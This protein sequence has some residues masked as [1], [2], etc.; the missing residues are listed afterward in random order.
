M[1]GLPSVGVI[2][3]VLI[4]A[5]CDHQAHGA[6]KAPTSTASPDRS[7]TTPAPPSCT[8]RGAWI[9][10]PRHDPHGEATPEKAVA[11]WVAY[12]HMPGYTDLAGPWRQ[13]SNQGCTVEFSAGQATVSAERLPDGTWLVLRGWRC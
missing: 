10:D 6:T 4:L 5:G 7:P 1:S 9:A 2:L 11:R 13:T 12:G 8:S 3:A